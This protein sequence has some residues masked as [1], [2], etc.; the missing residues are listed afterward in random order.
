MSASADRPT[1]C[2][3]RL[4][5]TC[6]HCRQPGPLV[7]RMFLVTV[8]PPEVAA[9]TRPGCVYA[10][11]GAGD[12]R[13][14]SGLGCGRRFEEGHAPRVLFGGRGLTAPAVLEQVTR[15]GRE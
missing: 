2:S 8:Q 6:G 5:S 12:E 10:G 4:V 1:R 15:H 13:G 9:P 14:A 7:N 11:R 3:A